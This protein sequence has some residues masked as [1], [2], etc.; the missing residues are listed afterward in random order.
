MSAGPPRAGER[1]PAP[2][3]G[4]YVA[5]TAV[6]TYFFT[7]G[8]TLFVP[9]N[10]FPRFI[11]T[12]GATPG[13]VSVTTALSLGIAAL[14]APFVGAVV[15]RFG[16][17]RVI[18]SGLLIMAVCFTLYPFARSLTDLYLLHAGLALGLVL[19]GLMAN[20]V[21]LSN[22][23][24]ARR[25]LVVGM[26]A[27]GSSLAGATLPLAIAPLVNAPDFGWR[28]GVGALAVA[29]WL[30]A[31]LP[32]FTVLRENPAAVGAWPD[33]AAA[34]PPA[35]AGAPATGIT[36]AD[37]LRTRSLWCLALGSACLW[38]AIQSMNSQ[39]TIFL[40]QDAG[41][42]PTRATLLFATIFWLSFAGK[43]LFG[44]LSDR[45]P[46]RRVMLVTSLTLL[47]GCLLLFDPATGRLTTAGPQLVAFAVVFGLGFGGSFTMIQLVAVET[48]GQRALGKILGVITLIDAL[49]AAA[50]TV[51]TGQLR[52]ATGDY[53]LPFALLTLV[54]LVAVVN[55]LFIRPV[56]PAG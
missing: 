18:R 16:V 13:Q 30:L 11:E 34:P 8:M 47:A 2:F 24:T 33:G 5:A 19:A 43:F 51:L 12:F 52:T 53:R 32:G 45:L 56:R 41:L 21:L 49:G 38:Y 10:L 9:Q 50:G 31:V 39:V 35:P 54:A 27:A 1:R 37:A 29:F 44:L 6:A 36:F 26:L 7:N 40:E 4:W 42:S 48:F 3:Y 20:V 23:F 22:W 14:L 46:K 28:W 15:D 55:V 25:G 17:V